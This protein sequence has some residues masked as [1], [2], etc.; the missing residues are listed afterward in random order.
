MIRTNAPPPCLY[1][2]ALGTSYWFD[3]LAA[4]ADR[5]GDGQFVSTDVPDLFPRTGTH[6]TRAG[7]QYLLN[8]GAIYPVGEQSQRTPYRTKQRVYRVTPSARAYV[9]RRR[10]TI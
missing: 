7:I 9:A 4:I 8:A 10:G 2:R 1:V 5:V 3:T 6:G